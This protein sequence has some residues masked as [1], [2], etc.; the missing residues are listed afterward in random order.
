MAARVR[1]CARRAPGP[2]AAAA[3]PRAAVTQRGAGARAPGAAPSA[4]PSTAPDPTVGATTEP[5]TEP[6]SGATPGSGTDPSGSASPSLATLPASECLTGTWQL[7]RFV[8]A[9]GQTYGTGQGGDVSVRFSGT[10]YRLTGA[11]DEPMTLT[12]AGRSA[13]LLVDGRAEGTFALQD[14]TATFRQRSASGS[15]T[16]KAGGDSQ[17]LS[18][19][20]VT[21]VVGLAGD[22]QVA[23]TADAMTVTLQN[24]RLE[25]GRSR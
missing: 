8:S 1:P 15:G 19:E 21:T 22:G 23:C 18:M 6:T 12:L 11:G 16:L 25:L 14:D 10:A 4:A 2:L 3:A 5:T 9:G 13:E 7:V 20:Q 24:V 17:R